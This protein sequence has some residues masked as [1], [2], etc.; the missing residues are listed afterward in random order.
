MERV[1]EHFQITTIEAKYLNVT[2][3]R[4]NKDNQ[5]RTKTRPHNIDD[6]T[7]HKFQQS[8]KLD[9]ELYNFAKSRYDV[10]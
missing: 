4:L 9:I 5:Y 1:M 7:L 3:L 8:N 2:T 10:S 6:M